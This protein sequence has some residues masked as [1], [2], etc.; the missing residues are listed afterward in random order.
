MYNYM[1]QKTFTILGVAG[2]AGLPRDSILPGS[3][4][5]LIGAT[6]ARDQDDLPSA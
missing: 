3:G 6:R 2:P 1:Y 4:S 5:A